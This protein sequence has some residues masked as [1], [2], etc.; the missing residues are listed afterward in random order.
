[1]AR[2]VAPILLIC[3]ERCHKSGGPAHLYKLQS[4][5]ELVDNDFG[6]ESGKERC[7]MM[8][9]SDAAGEAACEQALTR[10]ESMVEPG[11]PALSE[12]TIRTRPDEDLGS[13]ENGLSWWGGTARRRFGDTGDRRMPKTN[14]TPDTADDENIPTY[15]D[16][17]PRDY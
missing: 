5:A 2:Q 7:R 13:S 12:V 1:Y 8:F 14:L 15:F 16:T 11:A 6:Y 3:S 17:H 4:Q 10:S 9:G